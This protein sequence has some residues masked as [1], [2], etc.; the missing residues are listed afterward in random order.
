[1]PKTKQTLEQIQAK[2]DLYSTRG[3]F[4][5]NSPAAYSAAHKRGLLDKVCKH[6]APVRTYWTE[7]MLKAE[8]SLYKTRKAFRDN[9]RAAYSTAKARKLLDKLCAHMSET[10][11]TWTVEELKNEAKKYSTRAEFKKNNKSAYQAARRKK[12]LNV[13]CA[14]M[15]DIIHY[16]SKKDLLKEARKYKTRAEFRTGSNGA[17]QTARKR[18]L[19]DEICSHMISGYNQE[20][21]NTVYVWKIEG[22][23]K[24]KIGTTSEHLGVTRIDSVA[25][26]GKVCPE[27]IQLFYVGNENALRIEQEMLA[28]GRPSQF[29]TKFDGSTE[30]RD[31][32]FEEIE[33]VLSIARQA[34]QSSVRRESDSLSRP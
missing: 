21:R 20:S 12:I 31:L 33:Q 11:K 9:S 15:M 16:W 22:E 13:V 24:Y 29:C 1:M 27:W 7:E 3:A 2:A 5:E 19:L 6:M 30:F 17:Y 8:A 23:L 25:K 32:S 26:S 10:Y 34:A 28:I 14:H 4:C 18:K